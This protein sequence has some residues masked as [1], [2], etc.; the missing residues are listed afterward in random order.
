M[1]MK[2]L[3]VR[4]KLMLAFG[5]LAGIV[6]FVSALALQ[7]LGQSR[8]RFNAYVE[9]V[10]HREHLATVLRGAATRRAIAARNLVLVTQA[11]DR[12]VERAAVV[13]AHEGSGPA[14]VNAAR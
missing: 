4:T 8:D 11:A 2:D 5:A 9:G 3:S 6:L 12:E 13:T 10:G 14:S 7:S 1:A